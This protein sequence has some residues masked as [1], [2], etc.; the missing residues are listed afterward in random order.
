MEKVLTPLLK[1][2][3]RKA[4]EG[5]E[6]KLSGKNRIYK[7][8]S[9]FFLGS[10]LFDYIADH[11]VLPGMLMFSKF[12][13]SISKRFWAENDETLF[14]KNV[15]ITGATSGIGRAA[16]IKLA[17]KK[18]CLTIIARNENKAEKVRQQII[19]KTGNHHVDFLIADLS[20]MEDIKQVAKELKDK[21]RP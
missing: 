7:Q 5:L 14:E 2:T 1:N 11:M 17:G 13:Y 19:K 16:A 10:S 3:D 20:L 6:A 15:V 21:K 8:S 4:I 18:A 12:G 9:W